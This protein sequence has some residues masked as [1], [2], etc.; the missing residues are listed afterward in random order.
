MLSL[1]N[2]GL[3]SQMNNMQS[4]E[5][6][7]VITVSLNASHSL[8]ILKDA[9]DVLRS[10]CSDVAGFITGDVLLSQDGQKLAIVTEWR[11]SHAWSASRYGERVGKML[12]DCLANSS[13]LDFELY[14]R[15][16]RFVAAGNRHQR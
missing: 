9:I 6:V 7:S 5:V 10:E 4:S 2:I 3:P 12:E 8:D 14:N 1:Q 13:V 11:D 16:A 15:R